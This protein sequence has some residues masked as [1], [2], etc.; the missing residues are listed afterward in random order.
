MAD[1]DIWD[2]IDD[3]DVWGIPVDLVFTPPVSKSSPALPPPTFQQNPRS[4]AMF[5]VPSALRQSSSSSG[6]LTRDCNL[7]TGCRFTVNDTTVHSKPHVGMHR[8]SP[9]QLND[10]HPG[11]LE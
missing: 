10:L 11:P 8:A 1:D 4:P 6:A 5:Q 7:W 9:Y 3:T 2:L